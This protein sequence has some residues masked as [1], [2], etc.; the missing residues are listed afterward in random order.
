VTTVGDAV[1]LVTG[2]GS[3]LGAEISREL[4]SAGATVIG[5]DVRGDRAR[6]TGEGLPEGRYE[7][8]PLDLRER[9]AIAKTVN[10]IVDRYGRL[11]VVVNNAGIDR[12]APFEDFDFDGW[13]QIVD[14]NLV[15]PAA[16][17]HAAWPVMQ[18]QGGGAIVNIAST[19]AT[20][21]WSEASAYHAS[22]WGLLGL[23]RALHVEGR[24]HGIRVSTVIAGGMRTPFLLERFPDIDLDVLQDPA[25]V[26][27]A[28][29]LVLE[30]PAGSVIPELFVLPEQETSWP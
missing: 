18:R 21:A 7:A 14:V 27:H 26:A 25:N 10:A 15:A 16:V 9:A 2:A 29:R 6:E 20:R 23:S 1:T 13:E 8:W 22:K 3:G 19:A 28:V 11:D 4:V 12:T 5:A 30:M 24:P 17:M